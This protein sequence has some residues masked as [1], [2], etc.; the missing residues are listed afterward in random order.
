MSEL[1]KIQSPCHQTAQSCS[2]NSALEGCTERGSAAP[3]QSCHDPHQST[4]RRNIS[5]LS[6]PC[7]LRDEFFR[8]A[9]ISLKLSLS[10]L[11]VPPSLPPFLCS[12]S[13]P[14]HQ[15]GLETGLLIDSN[16]HPPKSSQGCWL[17]P[18]MSWFSPG[19]RANLH[20]QFPSSPFCPSQLSL[21]S[22]SAAEQKLQTGRLS[23]AL[24]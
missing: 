23:S 18:L 13:F 10:F 16:S 17:I 12:L 11:T 2:S 24:K 7:P 9:S 6:K 21:H 22:L 15:R 8:A 20:V 1:I 14:S 19:S 3:F 4:G 5:L